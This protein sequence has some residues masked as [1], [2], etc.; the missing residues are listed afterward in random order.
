MTEKSL[1]AVCRECGR[2]LSSHAGEK[3]PARCDGCFETFLTARD[4]DFLSSYAEL[5]VTSRRIIAE[6]SF[7]ALVMESPPHR[8][9]LAMNIMEQYVQAAGDLIG[10]YGALQSRGRA[11]VMRSLLEFKLD[12]DSAVAF[13]QEIA[14][15]SEYEL[16]EAMGLPQPDD[17]A[18]R[19]PS[20][21]KRDVKDLAR[22]LRQL[23]YDLRYTADQGETAA[24]AL[25]Q[26]A[27]ES[28]FGAALTNQSKWLDNVG[29]RPDQVAAIAIDGRRRTV[30]VTAI[31]VDEKKL[32]QVLSHINAM[33]RASQDL[34]YGVLSMHQEDQ[35]ARRLAKGATSSTRPSAPT[36]A[37]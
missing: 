16:L 36:P 8:K 35:R 28:R 15:K 22:A 25:A 31:S 34:I 1:E 18:R 29:L 12:R 14:T 37:G 13:F 11:P 33:T 24:L 6:T 17:V 23:T 32:E 4:A 7:R 9:V 30:S 26:M 5:G 19:C 10:L 20:L 2:P 21:S 3:R 27:G